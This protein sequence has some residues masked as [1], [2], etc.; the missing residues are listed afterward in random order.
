M[1]QPI[2]NP[3]RLS[4]LPE[5]EDP[6]DVAGLFRNALD[7]PDEA[8]PRL[9]WR[10]RT[11]LRRR[12]TRPSHLLRLALVVGLVFC[13]GGVVGAV[14]V[15]AHWRQKQPA[16]SP[17]PPAKPTPTARKH[18]LSPALPIPATPPAEPGVGPEAEPEFLPKTSS[19]A[20][21]GEWVAGRG[22]VAAGMEPSP[23]S[24][25]LAPSEPRKATR[26]AKVDRNIA[27]PAVAPPPVPPPLPPPAPTP[28]AMPAA[29]SSPIAVEQALL[30]RSMKTLRHGHDPKGA[31][32][33]LTEHA[34]RFPA[35]ALASEASVLRVEALLGLGRTTDALSILDGSSLSTTPN[36]DEQFVLRGELRAASGRWREASADFD[37]PLGGRPLPAATAKARTLQ[38]RALWGR[39]AAHSRLGD[40]TGARADLRLYLRVFPAGRFAKQ[41]AALLKDTP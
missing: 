9:R 17:P 11:S 39:A 30:A 29:V 35:G 34:Q 20:S 8:L 3:T 1:N 27:A 7:L 16:A 36:R 4:H 10:I 5:T 32:A 12:A 2:A 19:P 26:M 23:S 31:L 38:E 24:P 33:L 28:A 6:Q 22:A 15:A 40:E 18:R 13:L 14:V 37:E 25:A 21:P 41:A